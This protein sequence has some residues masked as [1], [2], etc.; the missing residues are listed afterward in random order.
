MT[1][2]VSAWIEPLHFWPTPADGVFGFDLPQVALLDTSQFPAVVLI[3]QMT[4]L[5]DG[6]FANAPDA[7]PVAAFAGGNEGFLYDAVRGD[8]LHGNH[9][10]IAVVVPI[11]TP[12]ANGRLELHWPA[13]YERFKELSASALL[14]IG[15]DGNATSFADLGITEAVD[16]SDGSGE[17]VVPPVPSRIGDV[18]VSVAGSLQDQV[19]DSA[20]VSPPGYATTVPEV[21]PNTVLLLHANEGAGA[22]ASVD[23]SPAAHT[24]SFYNGARLGAD[25]KFGRSSFAFDLANDVVRTDGGT[26]H[27]DF[28]VA[29]GVT[30]EFWIKHKSTDF[31]ADIA[32]H[33]F[34]LPS[35]SSENLHTHVT[36]DGAFEFLSNGAPSDVYYKS[37]GWGPDVDVWNHIAIVIT[38]GGA[39]RVYVDGKQRDNTGELIRNAELP[40]W[41]AMGIHDGT[42]AGLSA[43]WFHGNIDEVRFTREVL[44]S[45][46]F[47][48]PDGPFIVTRPRTRAGYRMLLGDTSETVT[49]KTGTGA[50][51]EIAPAFTFRLPSQGL[52]LTILSFDDERVEGG[53]FG[54]RLR[55]TTVACTGRNTNKVKPCC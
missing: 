27:A 17:V 30:I 15:F 1:T 53:Y 6:A 13:A 9:H 40:R 19:Y 14:V 52:G 5:D 16:P 35:S 50:T 24:V 43:R 48:A 3:F 34:V 22:T 42:N 25:C 7:P 55:G 37:G 28:S 49:W 38:A 2:P 11:R 4:H 21:I 32:A 29:G 18:L 46:D 54:G 44:Y 39:V 26:P 36:D 20:L 23:S 10:Q 41:V 8:G 31:S 45:A 51:S 47:T 12:P 33:Q